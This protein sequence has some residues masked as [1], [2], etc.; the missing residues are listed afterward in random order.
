MPKTGSI[1]ISRAEFDRLNAVCEKERCKPYSLVKRVLL[2]HIWAYPLEKAP[3]S[4]KGELKKDLETQN[5]TP[6]PET[7]EMGP[8][9]FD[10]RVKQ[11]LKGEVE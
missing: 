8:E 3:P 9:E 5:E 10:K 2:D 4:K 1:Y 7:Q 11:I 6:E